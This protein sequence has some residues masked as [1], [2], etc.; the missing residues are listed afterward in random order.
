[1]QG[2][3]GFRSVPATSSTAGTVARFGNLELDLRTGQLSRD[4]VWL[5]LQ[6]QPAK[7]LTILVSRPGEVI[8]REELVK[9]VWGSDTF[10]DF[11][12]GLNF[13][14]RQIRATLGDDADHPR[15]LE[16]LPKRGYRFIAAVQH[17]EAAEVVP[18][19]MVP[20]RLWLVAAFCLLLLLGT[21]FY[22][23]PRRPAV[24]PHATVLAVL[25]FD[26]LSPQ[27]EEYLVDS[28]TEEMIAQLTRVSPEVKVIARTS[29]MQYV[30]TKK[31][32]R[33]IG[34]ELGADYILENSVRH[35]GGRLRITTQLVRSSDQTHLWAENYD[36]EM[37]DLLPLE[38]EVTQAIAAQIQSHLVAPAASGQLAA[39]SAVDPEAHQVYLK[40]RYYFNQRSREGLE[41]S[42]ECLSRA[43]AQDPTY[44]AA[45]AGLADAYNVIAFYGF[46]PTLN[47]VA[48]AKI[49]A[50]KAVQLDDTMAAA[51]A[52]RAYT[53]FMWRGDWSIAEKEFKRALELDDNYVPAHQWYA[54]YLAAIGRIEE[55]KGQMQYA[56]QLD[57]LAPAVHTGLGYI[58]YFARDYGPAIRHVDTALQLNP[59]FMAG[60]AVL[61]WIYI[62]QKKYPEAITEMQTAAK[63]SGGVP[64]YVCGLAR[65]YAL[66][67]N[68]QEARRLLI[69][70]GAEASQPRGNGSALAALYLALGD[71]DMALHWLEI[72]ATGDIQA[73]WL[74]VDPAFDALRGNPRFEAILSRIGSKSE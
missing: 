63:L 74:R 33:E 2:T 58:D 44:A 10:V 41:K 66:A 59:N 57:P 30:H 60:H 26:D 5:R 53:E 39:V 50:D 65:A 6:P 70:A 49:A 24:A 17:D 54:L 11:E 14:I 40:G 7:V 72:T 45:Y 51:H 29:A 4:G 67:G 8:S 25:P 42:V 21:A 18:E 28:L 62:Q 47:T 61:G 3:L 23:W 34:Q 19:R 46:D 56:Q 13:A 69:Q 32:A 71:P 15:F 9:Q 38:S 22:L 1:M 27:P 43:V 55:A 16:T 37:R 12:Q 73:N 48:Q 68:V 31:S 64:V 36:R 20:Y 35:E 52:A